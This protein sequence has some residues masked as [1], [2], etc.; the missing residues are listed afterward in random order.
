MSIAM[1]G[2]GT[3]A[4][5]GNGPT[6]ATNDPALS[7]AADALVPELEARFKETY[8]G[9]VLKNAD[10]T[11]VVYRKP[12]NAL[13]EFVRARVQAVRVEL[14][15]SKISLARMREIR[16]EVMREREQWSANG[17]EVNGAGPRSDGSAV[18][19]FTARGA[20]E[21]QRAFDERYGEGTISVVPEK[22][23]D[24]TDPTLQTRVSP[25]G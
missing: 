11:M 12:D 15:D 24:A 9:V 13:D 2:C 21:E 14:S 10:R 3:R 6:S 23:M 8:S 20:P 7:A 1:A 25:R 4:P 22:P 19:V 16:D 5:V 17:I 18:E